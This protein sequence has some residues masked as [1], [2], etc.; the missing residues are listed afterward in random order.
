MLNI[1]ASEVSQNIDSA[2]DDMMRKEKW[3]DAN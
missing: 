1:N 3:T 2:F